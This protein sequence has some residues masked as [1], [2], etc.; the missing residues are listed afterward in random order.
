MP[1]TPTYGELGWAKVGTVN[2]YA[3]SASPEDE[4]ALYAPTLPGSFYPLNYAA[5]MSTP[6]LS[7]RTHPYANFWT[8]SAFGAWFGVGTSLR[9]GDLSEMSSNPAYSNGYDSA[10]I[11]NAKGDSFTLEIV[12][13]A[14]V[15]L[16]MNF[17]GVSTTTAGSAPAKG[18]HSP[19][20]Y[21]NVTFGTATG[22]HRAV[23]TYS[24]RCAPSGELTATNRPAAIIAG[25][26]VFTLTLLQKA[27]AAA[28]TTS[29]VMT[30]SVDGA[31]ATIT[32]LFRLVGGPRTVVAFGE[33]LVERVYTGMH[34]TAGD[35]P[36]SVVWS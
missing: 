18:T 32:M 15:A 21:H 35:N 9:N 17:M 13:G 34:M 19:A 30:I 6:V 22:V 7:V 2:L 23:L 29:E 11:T 10:A 14:P 16:T 28:P 20:M 33:T 12:Q 24:N 4:P 3:I 1:V 25:A 5:G 36:F 31:T 26:P 27:R 8:A